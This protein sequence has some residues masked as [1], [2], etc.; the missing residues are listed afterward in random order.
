MNILECVECMM[1][2]N[3][4]LTWACWASIA[5]ISDHSIGRMNR[6]R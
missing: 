5:A 6:D 2:L 1:I 4:R 3:I